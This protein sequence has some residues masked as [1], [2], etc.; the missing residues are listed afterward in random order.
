M[1][2]TLSKKKVKKIIAEMNKAAMNV[3]KSYSKV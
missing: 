1:K 3:L 2:K